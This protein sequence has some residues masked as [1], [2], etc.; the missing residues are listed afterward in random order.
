LLG[1]SSLTFAS[2]QDGSQKPEIKRN[3]YESG[4]NSLLKNPL[5]KGL[6]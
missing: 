4:S 3:H 2:S 5:A 6:S 1:R